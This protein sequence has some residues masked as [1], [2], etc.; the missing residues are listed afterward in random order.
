MLSWRF[1]LMYPPLFAVSTTKDSHDNQN[2][3]IDV[4]RKGIKTAEMLCMIQIIHLS[5]RHNF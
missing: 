3:N 5:S 4:I 2:K 1:F